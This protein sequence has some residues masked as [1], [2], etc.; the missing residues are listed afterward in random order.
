VTRAD[1]FVLGGNRFPVGINANNPGPFDAVWARSGEIDVWVVGGT[2]LD[3]SGHDGLTL[4]VSGG[5]LAGSRTITVAPGATLPNGQTA[6]GGSWQADPAY[7]TRVKGAQLA[8]GTA[9]VERAFW[10]RTV[11]VLLLIGAALVLARGWQIRRRLV[12]LTAASNTLSEGTRPAVPGP[13]ADPGPPVDPTPAVEATQV[14][15]PHPVR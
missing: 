10:G 7:V 3:V 2:L 1:L 9:Q 13:T 14:P 8:L 5:G 4:A 12:R 6:T 15:V 11:P